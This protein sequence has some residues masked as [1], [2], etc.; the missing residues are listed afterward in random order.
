MK[1]GFVD[2]VL[3]TTLSAGCLN[4][5]QNIGTNNFIYLQEST[6]LGR[7]FLKMYIVVKQNTGKVSVQGHFKKSSKTLNRKKAES[8][9]YKREAVR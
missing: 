2:S 7:V 9:R 8:M 6:Q 4:A 5:F 3:L 1:C